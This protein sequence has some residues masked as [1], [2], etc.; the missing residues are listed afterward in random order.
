[1][2]GV[3]AVLAALEKPELITHLVLAATSG[4][5]DMASF[6]AHDW[7]PSFFEANPSL[8][9]WFSSVDEDLTPELPTLN[10]PTLLLWGDADPISPVRVGQR[11]TSLLPH[12]ELHIFPG[13]D[14][15]LANT[16]AHDIAPLI[17]EHLAKAA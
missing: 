1:M 3:I 5:M 14:H 13:G 6:G 2:G 17:D 11:L 15:D 10:I 4:G 16:L 9:R 8:P 12:A 7:R